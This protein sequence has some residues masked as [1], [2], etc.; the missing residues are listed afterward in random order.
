MQQE[1]AEQRA[2]EGL[3]VEQNAGLRCGN[4]GESPVPQQCSGGGAEQTAGGESEPD[5]ERDGREVRRAK[6]L[7][8]EERDA[9]KEHGRAAG[10]AVGG[11]ADRAVALHQALVEEDPG[12]RDDQGEDDEQISGEGGV[13]RDRWRE[14]R[15]ER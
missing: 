10:D 2:D 12:E 11:D 6:G 13:V 1:D 4:L 7:V 9:N 5:L 3:H 14:A 8:V 15:R